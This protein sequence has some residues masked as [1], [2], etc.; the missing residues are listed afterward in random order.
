MNADEKA[1]IDRL[2]FG[3]LYLYAERAVERAQDY[4]DAEAYTMAEDWMDRAEYA[5]DRIDTLNGKD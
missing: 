4:L 2:S 3:D 1:Y 5:M